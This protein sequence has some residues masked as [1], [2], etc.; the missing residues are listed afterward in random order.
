[1]KGEGYADGNEKGKLQMTRAEQIAYEAGKTAESRIG[2][3]A[4]CYDPI[5]NN[6]IIEARS[7]QGKEYNR[8]VM[9]AWYNG[10][11]WKILTDA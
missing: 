4:I 11:G 1:M 10:R 9:C 6:L 2:N 7:E 5:M 3:K 8:R